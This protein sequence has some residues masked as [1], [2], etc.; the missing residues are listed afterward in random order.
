MER[1][2]NACQEA[3]E[4][5]ENSA[6]TKEANE[7]YAEYK[8]QIDAGNPPQLEEGEDPPQP[9]EFNERYF[10][11]NWDEENP[12]IVIPNEVSDDIDNDWNLTPEL[13]TEKI[14]EFIAEKVASQEPPPP[15]PK[16]K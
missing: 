15:P 4:A 1:R 16:K 7:A 13:K 6:D 5:F 2:A 3:K 11:F 14:D 8:A 9:K 10:L 12:Q